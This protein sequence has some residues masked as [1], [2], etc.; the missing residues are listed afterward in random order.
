M[1]PTFP[2][3]AESFLSAGCPSERPL[4]SHAVW[5]V[6]LKLVVAV[7]QRRGRYP[8]VALEEFGTSCSCVSVYVE[9]DKR[10]AAYEDCQTDLGQK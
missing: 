3:F 10:G 7:A 2:A 6:H 9:T 8:A 5:G 1:H 4:L